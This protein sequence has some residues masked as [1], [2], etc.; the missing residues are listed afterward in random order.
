MIGNNG[1]YNEGQT[2]FDGEQASDEL[3]LYQVSSGKAYVK[4][5]EVTINKTQNLLILI[6]QEL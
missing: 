6:N 5:Y 2:T 4:G 3:G 1:V